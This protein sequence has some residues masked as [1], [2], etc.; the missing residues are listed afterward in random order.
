MKNNTMNLTSASG[1]YAIAL[2][3]FTPTGRSDL[4]SL[5]SMM[6]FY[7]RC[8]VTGLTVLGVMGEARRNSTRPNARGSA[9]AR[10]SK[11][12]E[13]I[14]DHR[15]GV[16][17]GFAAMRALRAGID[18]GGR[19]GRDDRAAEHACAPTTRSSPITRRAAAAIGET[20]RS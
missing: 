15:R 9:A 16:R 8:G 10:C 13:K 19:G 17:P 2:T 14:A 6:E 18:G 5:D 4:A 12:R 7:L 3:P 1:V 20:S 11:V